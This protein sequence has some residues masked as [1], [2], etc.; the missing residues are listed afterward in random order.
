M[1]HLSYGDVKTAAERIDGQVR[2]VTLAR[3][4]GGAGSSGTGSAA[5]GERFEL[6]L[7]LEF[8]QHTGTFKARGA[9]NFLLAHREQGTLPNAGVTIASGGNAGL[10]CAWAAREQGVPATV[11]VPESAPPVKV[12]RLRAYGADVRFAGT[13]YAEAAAACEEFV[14]TTGALASHAYDNPLIAAG[15][16]TLV[17]EIRAQVPL[18]DTIVVSVGGGGLFSGVAAAAQHHGIRVVAVEPERCR[19]LNAAIEAGRVVDV[20]VDSVA[21]D[22][23]G[24]RRATPMALAAAGHRN[25][26]SVLVPDAAVVA[27]RRGLWESHRLAVEHAAGAALAGVVGEGAP[28]VP[29]SGER[30]AVVLCG[31]N[32][33]LGDL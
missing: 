23:L 26:R 2:T 5:Q 19:A 28:Y 24:A 20:P 18:L 29:A 7:A 1:H 12:E 31:A 27:A 33:E 4:S 25:V 10:A 17:E 15:A 6:W 21:A 11:F 3:G 32:T 30:V 22:S 9:R 8:L 14:A 16:G 13:E